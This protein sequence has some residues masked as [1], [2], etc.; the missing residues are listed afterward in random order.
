[1]TREELQKKADEIRWW[2]TM[3]LGFGVVTRGLTDPEQGLSRMRFPADLSGKRVLDVGTWDGFFAFEAERRGAADVLA[4]DSFIWNQNDGYWT[5]RRGFNLAHS[6]LQSRVRPLE[7]D[8][9]D[10]SPESV[11]G[12]FDIVLFLGVLYHLRHPLLALERMSHVAHDLMIVET[13]VDNLLVPWSSLAFYP[14][15]ELGDDPTNWFG[16]NVRAAVDLLHVAGFPYV[17]VVYRTP[18]Q[19][20]FAL[21]LTRGLKGRKSVIREVGRD[22]VVLH[23]SKKQRFNT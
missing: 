3:D 2:H 11:G 6:A 23:A 8:V 15:R 1:M 16:P 20:R 21:G 7:I 19:R 17:A 5:G 10:I 13:V 4:T 14:E 9:M 18:W 12:T 22:R